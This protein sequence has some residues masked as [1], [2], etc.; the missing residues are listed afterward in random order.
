MV[1]L[2]SNQLI[3]QLNPFADEQDE[4]ISDDRISKGLDQLFGMSMAERVSLYEA[5][6]IRYFLPKYNIEFKKSFPSTNLKILNG[7]Y[8]KDF[9]AVIAEYVMDESCIQLFSDNVEMT[10]AH[11]AHFDLH[12][13]RDRHFFFS[14]NQQP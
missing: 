3:T 10:D 8:D 9:S 5:A 7:V 4:K 13:T 1:E 11:I 12:K 6:M 14:S 2:A